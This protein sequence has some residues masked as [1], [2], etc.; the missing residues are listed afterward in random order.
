LIRVFV[1]SDQNADP[2]PDGLLYTCSVRIAS[3]TLPGNFRLTNST[4]LAFSPGGMSLSGVAGRSGVIVVSLVPVTCTGDCN[5]DGEVSIDELI[6]G[7]AIALGSLPLGACSTLD[8]NG[9]GTV[10]VNE[11]IAAVNNALYGCGVTPLVFHVEGFNGNGLNQADAVGPTA[12][13]VDVVQDLC[14]T[15]PPLT[16]ER[17]TQTEINAVF[18]NHQALDI[19]LE[20]FSLHVNDSRVGLGDFTGTLTG[21]ILGGR[22]SSQTDKTC[23]IDDD[24]VQAGQGTT[25]ATCTHQLTT[26]NGIV[27]FDFA[28]KA[29][30][31]GQPNAWG[32]AL[33][34][35]ITFFAADATQ[36]FQ[37]SGG[38]LVTF[39]DFDNCS[40]TSTG[41]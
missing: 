7:V 37:T 2:I 13:Q 40:S 6:M 19:H 29:Q 23:A 22:C 12:A 1:E 33:P 5:A 17:F 9:D 24:C 10:T 15:A 4:Q 26:I 41:A 21:T 38:Y 39:V 14:G 34:V 35:T 18:S 25:S 16:P 31:A 20:A 36:S 28:A 30:V 8:F 3:S 32:Q 11:L 27:L